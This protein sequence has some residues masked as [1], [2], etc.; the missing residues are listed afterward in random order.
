ML[1][2]KKTMTQFLPHAF[3]NP[4]QAPGC[5]SSDVIWIAFVILTHLIDAAIDDHKTNLY[6]LH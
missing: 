3:L 1:I 4:L 2:V 6:H 5:E